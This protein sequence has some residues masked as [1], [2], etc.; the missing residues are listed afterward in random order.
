MLY[1]EK[2]YH[3]LKNIKEYSDLYGWAITVSE[4]KKIFTLVSWAK[5]SKP[6]AGSLTLATNKLI[7]NEDTTIYKVTLHKNGEITL[8]TNQGWLRFLK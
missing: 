6:T 4:L 5:N 8:I 3:T 2:K 1:V 7:E